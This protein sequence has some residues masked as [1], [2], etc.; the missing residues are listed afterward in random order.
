VDAKGSITKS[1]FT[2]ELPP[3]IE[4]LFEDPTS[5]LIEATKEDAVLAPGWVRAGGA[6]GRLVRELDWANTP[7]GPWIPV[8]PRP[9]CYNSVRKSQGKIAAAFSVVG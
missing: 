8:S 5:K 3:T 1:E 9:S 7:L 4:K 2:K 6:L